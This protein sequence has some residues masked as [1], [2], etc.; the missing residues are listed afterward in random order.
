[1]ASDR[2]VFSSKRNRP[3]LL[4]GRLRDDSRP[5][6]GLTATNPDYFLFADDSSN[7][8]LQRRGFA[9][10]SVALSLMTSL[11]DWITSSG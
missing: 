10:I 8:V 7:E 2:T 1:M 4:Y 5:S 11:I 9:V 6:H 3:L